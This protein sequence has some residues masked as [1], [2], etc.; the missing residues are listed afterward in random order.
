LASAL[1]V[2]SGVT[3]RVRSSGET[4]LLW[5][6]REAERLLEDGKNASPNVLNDLGQRLMDR[7]KEERLFLDG[8]ARRDDTGAEVSAGAGEISQR[9]ELDSSPVCWI[10]ATSAKR[11]SKK[12][13]FTEVRQTAPRSVF[14]FLLRRLNRGNGKSPPEEEESSTTAGE[15]WA[16]PVILGFVFVPA[17][18]SESDESI[19]GVIDPKYLNKRFAVRIRCGLQRLSLSLYS[20]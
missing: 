14:A 8:E 6:A 18:I 1:G 11:P 12:A 2:L 19:Y 16:C 4:L 5:G 13:E 3:W 7:F 15:S 17:T 9:T 20:C 10:S